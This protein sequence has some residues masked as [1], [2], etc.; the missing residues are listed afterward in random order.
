MSY[1]EHTMESFLF[2][3]YDVFAKVGDE[4]S[5]DGDNTHSVLPGTTDI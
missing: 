3:Q 2:E 1:N 5:T 4:T